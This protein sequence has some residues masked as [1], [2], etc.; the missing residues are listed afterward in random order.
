M[1]H[2]SALLALLLLSLTACAPQLQPP[3]IDHAEP[4]LTA[5]HIVMDDGARL[6]LRQWQPTGE[7]KAIILALHG[8]N[9]YSNAFDEPARQWAAQG[10]ATFAYDQ[11]GFGDTAY[12]GV[13]AG[14]DRMEDDL[15]T[16]AMLL[17]AR[18]PQL[19]L[20]LLGE[21]MGGAVIMAAA[22]SDRPPPADGLVLAA[23]AVWGRET[24]GAVLSGAL[25]IAAHTMPWMTVTGSGLHIWPSD[26]VPM[27]RK[28][29]KDPLVIKET[30][31]DA[32]W[33]LTNLMD[34]AFA[35]APR[36][37]HNTL[38][39]YGCREQVLPDGAVLETLRRLSP[40]PSRRPQV[41]L[42]AKGYHMLLRDLD[43]AIVVNDVVAWI[44][45]PGGSLP[46]RGDV[47]AQRLLD[48]SADSLKAAGRTAGQMSSAR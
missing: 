46:S 47:L 33:G 25:W 27:L 45:N 4:A 21:S 30:R 35:A 2:F 37:D 11:R 3:S 15:R 22:G 18:Y 9:D 32:L 19:P 43:S 13:W 6:P 12:R 10:I 41:A 16:A 31:V 39:L 5:D 26:N 7:P 42:Y 48:G 38:V 44:D 24:Q 28:L 14:E 17:R 40:D 8:F 20:Y 29:A 34:R 1:K 23:P 36:L